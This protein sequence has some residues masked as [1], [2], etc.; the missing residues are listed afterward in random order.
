MMELDL[1]AIGAHPDDVEIACGGTIAKLVKLGYR[2][3]IL[4]LTEG[5]MGTRGTKEIRAEESAASAK[6]LGVKIREN[7]NLGDGHFDNTKVNQLKIVQL[8]RKYKPRI[9]L[10]PHW[11]ERHPD[12]VHAH[13]LAKEA[14]FYS[15]LEKV[16]TIFA[17]KSQQAWRPHHYF[18]Y[19]QT[20]EFHPS[21]IVDI[22]DVHDAR[23]NALAAFKS[24]FYDPSSKEPQTFLSSKYFLDLLETRMKYFGQKIGVEYGEPFLSVDTPGISNLF[25]LKFFKG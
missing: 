4:D 1:L 5:E 19:M 16:E 3:G 21:F 6:I 24:Q 2:V 11:H 23:M 15:G 10:I 8:F 14:W 13:Y 17:G 22:S 25:D 9:I 20:Y 7:L 18:H 12:H